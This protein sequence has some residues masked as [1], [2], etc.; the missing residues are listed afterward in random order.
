MTM[1]VATPA[2]SPMTSF[3]RIHPQIPRMRIARSLVR[4]G[5]LDSASFT[6]LIVEALEVRVARIAAGAAILVAEL[7]PREAVT[8]DLGLAVVARRRE[9]DEAGD[10]G[11]CHG[12]HGLPFRAWLLWP[13]GRRFGHSGP[14]ECRGRASAAGEDQVTRG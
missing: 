7:Q 11:C 10:G 1:I 8:A 14:T 12:T 13:C 3:S 4:N 6:P 2:S 9:E 5:V